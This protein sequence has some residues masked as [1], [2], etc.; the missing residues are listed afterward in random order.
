MTN[1]TPA[2]DAL[3][4]LNSPTTEAECGAISGVLDLLEASEASSA[5]LLAQINAL[6]AQPA[7]VAPLPIVN[8]RVGET[9]G[10]I[11]TLRTYGGVGDGQPLALELGWD[12]PSDGASVTLEYRGNI[13]N[14][15]GP[16]EWTQVPVNG[17]TGPDGENATLMIFQPPGSVLLLRAVTSLNGQVCAVITAYVVPAP[18]A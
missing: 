7:P 12:A 9:N 6:T 13:G 17:N 16:Q 8:F 2:R 18:T 3:T 15:A 1:T 11:G 14:P 5:A 4:S 10:L